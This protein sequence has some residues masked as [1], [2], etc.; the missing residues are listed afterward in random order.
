M[1]KISFE[2]FYLN[3]SEANNVIGCLAAYCNRT[4]LSLVM[5][6]FNNVLYKKYQVALKEC[7]VEDLL[8][9]RKGG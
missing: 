8:N 5:F 2:S 1:L 9:P 7:S 6:C 3:L 4:F